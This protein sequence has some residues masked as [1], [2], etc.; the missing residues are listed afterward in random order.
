MRPSRATLVATKPGE[1]GPVWLVWTALGIV[2]LVWGS[3]YLAIRVM[4][5]TMPPLFGAGVR[6][7]AAGLLLWAWLAWR[8]GPQSLT[9]TRRQLGSSALVGSALLLGG[10]G[11]VSVAEQDIPSGLAALL[12]SS[13]PL[14]VVLWRKLARERVSAV[15]LGGVLIGFLGVG[16]LV[17]PGARAGAVE[18]PGPLLVVAAAVFWATGSFASGKIKLPEDAFVAT[19]YEMLT[20]GAALMIAGA[21]AGELADVDLAGMSAASLWAFLY[22]IVVGSLVAFTAYVWLLGNAPISKVATYAYVNPVVAVFLG[23]LILGEPLSPPIVLGAVLIVASVAFIVRYETR[24][25]GPRPTEGAGSEGCMEPA[26]EPRSV[27]R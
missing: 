5:E 7:F 12:I 17:L 19:A 4:V 15:T 6:F 11:L 21:A 20:G 2:Y 22:L 24:Q 16:V 27:N 8:R 23:W 3:T 9:V 25:A 13:V 1:G 10:N 26:L 14:W 18:G